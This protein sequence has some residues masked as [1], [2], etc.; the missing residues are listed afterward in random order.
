MQYN[1]NALAWIATLRDWERKYVLEFISDERPGKAYWHVDVARRTQLMA[2]LFHNN[3]ATAADEHREDIANEIAYNQRR[4]D[5]RARIAHLPTD[6][7]RYIMRN[8]R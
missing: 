6:T 7:Q 5:M 3:C 2:E 1:E 8:V 4:A